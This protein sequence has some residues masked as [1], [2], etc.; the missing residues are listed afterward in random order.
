[1]HGDRSCRPW[2]AVLLLTLCLSSSAVAQHYTRTDL[3]ANSAAV[4]TGVIVDPNLVNA[5]GLSRASGSPWWI[6][7]NGTGLS[8]LYDLTGAPQP[9]GC[10]RS[11]RPRDRTAHPLRPAPSSISPRVSKSLQECRPIFLFVTENGTI[12]GWNP[13][14]NPTSAVTKRDRSASRV[15]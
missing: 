5:W 14:V 7:D 9:S 3:T 6:S 10:Y 11:R 15:L 13:G 4:S 8:T 1:M 12:A 2:V